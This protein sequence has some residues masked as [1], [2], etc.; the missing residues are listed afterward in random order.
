M[1]VILIAALLS[2]CATGQQAMTAVLPIAAD[3]LRDLIQSHGGEVDESEAVCVDFEDDPE[4]V[5]L[6]EETG[7]Y[8]VLCSGR[9]K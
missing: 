6:Q 8:Y 3:A 7:D 5:K 1:R 9:A 4:V 2:G